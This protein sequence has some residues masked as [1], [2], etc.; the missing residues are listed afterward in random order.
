MIYTDD[1]DIKIDGVILPGLVKSLEIQQDAQIDEED[2]EGSTSKPKQ[3][4]GYEDA[5]IDIEL[6]LDDGP[7]ETLQQK[8]TKI[9]NLFKAKT[10]GIPITRNIV[11]E[12][13]AIWGIDKVLFK[14]LGSKKTNTSGQLAVSIELWEYVPTTITATKSSSSSSTSSSSSSSTTG[15]TAAGGL[16]TAYLKYLR[17]DRGAAP[18][19]ED[20]TT[21]TP[22]QDTVDAKKYKTLLWKML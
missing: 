12:H 21:S 17:S 6:I 11:N 15:L 3:A 9:K 20:K 10:Q 22:A 8:L 7:S 19:I 1:S 18:K 5:K 16:D 4:T 13:T 14:H 2:V